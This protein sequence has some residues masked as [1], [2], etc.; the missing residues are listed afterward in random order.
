MAKYRGATCRLCRREGKKLFLKGTKC[1]SPKCVFEKRGYAPGMFGDDRRRRRPSDYGEQ[2]REKQRMRTTYGVLER[3]FRRHVRQ[4][5][6][7]EGVT[8]DLLVMSLERR[9]D[10]VVYRAGLAASR[11][12]ARQIVSHRHITVN[13]RTVNVPS[14]SVRIG[15]VIRIKERS[16]KLGPIALALANEGAVSVPAWLQADLSNATVT[17]VGMPDPAEVE[18]GADEQQVIEFYSR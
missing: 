9:L 5:Q 4:A 16:R 12:Q 6:R 3:Q 14:F 17:V 18:T 13:D 15:D 1:T 11:P 10:N 8:A 2:L 7:H